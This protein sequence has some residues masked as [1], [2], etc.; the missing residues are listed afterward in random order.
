MTPWQRLHVT[1]RKA[2]CGTKAL[3]C[4]SSIF[5]S[6]T[7]LVSHLACSQHL[8]MTPAHA[9][10]VWH[11]TPPNKTTV[12]YSKTLAGLGKTA[13]GDGAVSGAVVMAISCL[14]TK[15]LSSRRCSRQ[16]DFCPKAGREI[17]QYNADW[18][19]SLIV[20]GILICSVGYQA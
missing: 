1:E 20:W 11:K 3:P 13:D 16:G 8:A 7:N 17:G 4:K 14:V 18:L 12:R 6:P 15:P 2:T 19:P 10:V 5:Y 9:P